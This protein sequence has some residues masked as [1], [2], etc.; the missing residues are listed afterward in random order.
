MANSSVIVFTGEGKGKTEAALGL[1]LRAL[2]AGFSVAFIQFIKLQIV[3]ED[4]TLAKLA[5][6]YPGK[7]HMHKGGKGF[8]FP[9]KPTKTGVPAAQHR[10][11][12]TATYAYALSLAQSG[13]L[14]L[15][16][17]DEVNNAVHDHLLTLHQLKNLITS[18]HPRTHLCLTGRNFPNQ[19]LPLVDYATDM[20]KQKHPFDQGHLAIPGIDY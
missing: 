8:Y 9:K 17:A 15:V 12:A 1:T 16:I 19:L 20:T 18:R 7:M 6:L 14:D 13:D 10:A 3:A 5:S 4:Q 2:G 11:T